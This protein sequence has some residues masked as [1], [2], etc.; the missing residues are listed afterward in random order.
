MTLMEIFYPIILMLICYLIKLAFDSTKVTWEDEGGLDKYLISKGNF[1]FDYQIYPYLSIFTQLYKAGSLGEFPTVN[2][3][4]FF[5]F[6]RNNPKYSQLV[7]NLDPSAE[8]V[9]Q[10]RIIDIFQKLSPDSGVWKYIDPLEETHDIDV[11]TIAG[12]PVK[13]IT[14]I[15]Y[16]RFVIALVGFTE[17]DDLG[18][19][20]KSYISIENSELNRPYSFKHFDSISELNDYITAEDYGLSNKPSIC[21]GIYFKANGGNKYSASL[22]YFNDVI[23]PGIEDVPNNIKPLHEEMQQGPN[24]EDIQKYSD[25]GYI[26][27]LNILANYMLKQ[28]NPSY[29]INYGFAVQK[30]DVYRFNEF[31]SYAGVYFTF[32]VILSYLCPL[33]LYVLKMVVE[34]ESRAKE[35]MKIMGMGEGTYFLSYFVEYFIVNIIYAFAVGYISKL[36]FRFIPYMYLVL[37]LWLFGL[38]IF[39]LAFFCQSFMDTTRL[40]LIVSCLIYCLMLFVSAA[41]YDDN[42]KKTYKIIA[43]LLPPVNLLLGA[44]TIGEFERMFFYFKTKNVDKNYINYSMS[45]CY[46]MFTVD[47]FIYLFLG[48]YLQNVIPHEYGVA[49]PWY[50]LFLPSYWFGD[51]C[52]KKNSDL[53]YETSDKKSK[54]IKTQTKKVENGQNEEI[55]T[56]K[57]EIQDMVS[58]SSNNSIFDDN[59]HKGNDDFQNEDIYRDKDKKNDVF[60]LREVTKVYG[61]GK[62]ACNKISFNLFRNEIFALLGRNGAGKTSLINV[63]IGM[64]DAT[65]GK[66][67][68]KNKNILE[69]SNMNEFRNKLGICPQHDILFPKLTVREHLEMFCYFKGFD[70]EKIPEEVDNTLKDFRIHDIENVLAGTLSAGQRRKLSIAIS[71]IGGSEVIFLDEP[72]SGMDIT[73]R[74]NLWEILKKIIEKRIIILTTHYMEEASVLG[75]RIGIMAEGVLKCRKIRKIFICEYL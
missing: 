46:I 34:K 41:V 45:T 8:T 27:V 6:L 9:I 70:V 72:S 32:F 52:K 49:K 1:G 50:F 68:Y 5:T 64:Y 23:S 42:I 63:L 31:A 3:N 24:M 61:D 66:A 36:T 29:Y 37:Y 40:A 38:N 51:C 54:K 58:E 16:N 15:C 74:R 62:M 35:V 18:K 53:E 75:N 13:P 57:I 14:M 69:E 4:N 60:M 7:Q 73:S 19:I 22:H 71:V 28:K 2:F 67:I 17:D 33:I 39:A 25:D 44:F 48:Y 20:I 11:N 30:Y 65:S 43:A 55:V 59:P 10:S 21:F 47:F 12:L 26:Q 56:E